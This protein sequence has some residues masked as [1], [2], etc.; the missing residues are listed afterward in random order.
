MDGWMDGW[1][2]HW[3]GVVL[4]IFFSLQWMDFVEWGFGS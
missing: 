1:M 4:M 2:M 3:D